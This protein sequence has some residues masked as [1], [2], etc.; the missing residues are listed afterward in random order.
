MRRSTK[1]FD[2]VTGKYYFTVKGT[3]GNIT[4]HRNNKIEAHQVYSNYFKLG[5]AVE[6]LGNWNGKKF[7]ETKPPTDAGK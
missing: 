1:K 3:P 5:K 2:Y 6:W 4:M 7:E